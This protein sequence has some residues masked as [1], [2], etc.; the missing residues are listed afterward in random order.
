MENEPTLRPRT[1]V[2]ENAFKSL[3]DDEYELVM[4]RMRDLLN[5]D[6]EVESQ[7]QGSVEV[8]WSVVETFSIR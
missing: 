4:R 2:I 3:T 7:R 6:P 1:D 5:V 8:L